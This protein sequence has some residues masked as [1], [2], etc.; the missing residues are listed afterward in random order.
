MPYEII[1][2]EHEAFPLEA[3]TVIQ[4]LSYLQKIENMQDHRWPKTVKGK[5]LN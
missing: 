3:S 4:L 2:V 5:A 1:L